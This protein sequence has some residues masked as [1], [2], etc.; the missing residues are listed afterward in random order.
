MIE[1]H[2]RFDVYFGVYIRNAPRAR[3]LESLKDMI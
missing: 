3:S 1:H 2:Q